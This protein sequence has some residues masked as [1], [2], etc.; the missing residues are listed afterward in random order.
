MD[1]EGSGGGRQVTARS[2]G[3]DDCSFCRIAHGDEHPAQVVAEGE[4]WIAFF[5]LHPATIGHTLVIPR[6]HVSDLWQASPELAGSLTGQ[7][8]RVGRAIEL[9]L[10]PDG[11]NL[12]TSKGA[13]AEQSIFH[14]HLHLVPRWS[15]DGFGTIWPDSSADDGVDLSKVAA[16]IRDAWRTGSS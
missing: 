15:G 9:A 6:V 11:M 12:I 14:L 10:S 16:S 5:P 3:V 8:V 2:P 7:C 13:A 4:D 1:R